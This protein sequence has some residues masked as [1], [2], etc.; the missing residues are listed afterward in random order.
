MESIV[1]ISK[2]GVRNLEFAHELFDGLLEVLLP[3]Q[4]FLLGHLQGLLVLT[5]HLDVNIHKC[6]KTLYG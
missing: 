6:T 3:I 4:G 5:Y 2:P 1:T